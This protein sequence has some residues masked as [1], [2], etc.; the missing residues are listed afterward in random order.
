MKINIK[1]TTPDGDS[2]CFNHAVLA[3]FKGVPILEELSSVDSFFCEWCN[4]GVP[5]EIQK[6]EVKLN[7]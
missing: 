3:V 1:R 2:L 5:L 7:V 4:Y 6:L